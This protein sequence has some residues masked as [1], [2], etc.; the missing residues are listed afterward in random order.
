LITASDTV[1][2][3]ESV[4]GVAK[5][6][7][8]NMDVKCPFCD[9]SKKKR[10]SIRIADH[11]CHCWVCGWGG[12]LFRLV[13]KFASQDQLSD[14]KSR[15][16]PELTGIRFKDDEA[17]A[18]N[19]IRLPSDFRLLMLQD[20]TIDP[21]VRAVQ[22][23]VRS[24]GLDEADMWRWRLGTSNKG[25]LRRR[26]IVP[27]FDS[28][29]KVNYFTAR[30]IDDKFFG[31]KYA[32]A[33]RNKIEVV[34]N[35]LNIDWTQKLVIVEGPFD[36]MKCKMNATCLLG[37]SLSPRSLLFQRI[38][39]HETPVVLMLDD[40]MQEKCQGIG[41]LLTSFNIPVSIVRFSGQ[42]DPGEMTFK[43]V[44]E[45][46]ESAVPWSWKSFLSY[47]IAAATSCSLKI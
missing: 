37:S 10:L 9:D 41:R 30:T 28:E 24:R 36:L 16:L 40:E 8:A 2:F 4:F 44:S 15:F 1:K 23:Y 31:G 6:Y 26:V 14:Y 33:E 43:Q 35:E 3:V 21:D 25:I 17:V 7:A 34:F 47:K 38:I 39:E 18:S 42:H 12:P 5:V 13:I 45:Y 29:G 20:D 19:V 11:I 32:N 27:S 46:V 22:W